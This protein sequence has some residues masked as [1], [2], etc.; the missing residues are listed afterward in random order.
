MKKYLAIVALLT[1]ATTPAMAQ[2]LNPEFGTGNV[3]PFAYKAHRAG[4]LDWASAPSDSIVR[5]PSAALD[6]V[7]NGPIRKYIER[8]YQ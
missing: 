4:S 3:A 6:T 1:A 8:H 2:A 7:G 5:Y